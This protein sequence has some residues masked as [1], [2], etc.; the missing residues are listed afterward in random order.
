MRS[1]RS[2][3]AGINLWA[4]GW[5]MFMGSASNGN[6]VLGHREFFESKGFMAAMA[7]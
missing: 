4:I 5:P 2:G 3:L 6:C 7:L 1:V